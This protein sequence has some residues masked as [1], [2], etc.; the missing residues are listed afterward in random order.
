LPNVKQRWVVKPPPPPQIQEHEAAYIEHGRMKAW[1][2][3]KISHLVLACWK[4]GWETESACENIFSGAAH[5]L[6]TRG[7]HLNGFME[8]IAGAEVDQEAVEKVI[9][10]RVKLD[11]GWMAAQ[12]YERRGRPV[13]A[14]EDAKG[15]I[16]PEAYIPT[17]LECVR[18]GKS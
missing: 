16:F 8:A 15:V 2:D 13:W 17:F 14:S 18:G 10:D 3:R 12:G 11:A 6:F 4:R 9:K 1:V 7:T 5:I